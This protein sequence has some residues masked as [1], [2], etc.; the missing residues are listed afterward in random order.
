MLSLKSFININDSTAMSR[1]E[2]C[3]DRHDLQSCKICAICV[4]FPGKQCDFSRNLRRTTR[5]AHT[6]CD[7]AL[8]LLK[9]YTLT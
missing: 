6:K 4:I 7:F 8:N 1:V 9:I 3:R 5:F 2:S